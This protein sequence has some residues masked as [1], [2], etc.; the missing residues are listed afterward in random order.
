MSDGVVGA[1]AKKIV[2]RNTEQVQGRG[3]FDLLET[4]FA[5]DFVDHTPATGNNA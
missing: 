1:K 3:D 4:L 5:D 2:R